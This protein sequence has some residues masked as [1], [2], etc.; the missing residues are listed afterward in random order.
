MKMI[1]VAYSSFPPAGNLIKWF[2]LVVGMALGHLCV[3]QGWELSIGGNSYDE[4]NAIEAAV[5]GG[6]IIVGFSESFGDDGDLDVLVTR[7]DIDGRVLWNRF[8]DEGFQE[9]GFDVLSE[10]DGTFLVVGDIKQ[11]PSTPFNVLLMKLTKEGKTLWSRQYDTPFREVGKTLTKSSDGGYLIA[12]STEDTDNGESDILLLKVDADGNFQWRKNLGTE[13]DDAAER[14]ITLEDGFLVAANSDNPDRIDSDIL[15]YKVDKTG[16]V[17]WTQRDS[18]STEEADEVYG[19]TLT[20]DKNIVIGGLVGFNSDAYI[21]KLDALTGKVIWESRIGG[22]MGDKIND[23]FEQPD[24]SLIGVG[25][26]EQSVSNLDALLV[27]LDAEGNEI[28]QSTLGEEE[29]IEYGVQV[30]PTLDGKFTFVGWKSEINRDVLSD[31]YLVKA[32]GQGNTITNLV[33]GRVYRD[34]DEGCNGYDLTRDVPLNDWLVQVSGKENGR[35]Y[36]GTTDEEG[37]YNILVDTGSYNV[38]VLPVNAYWSN[39]V[40]AGYEITLT[41]F[42]DTTTLNFPVTASIDCPYLEVDV[43][44]PF[45]TPCSDIVYTVDYCNIGTTGAQDAYVE[46]TLDES[47]EF[48]EADLPVAVQNNNLY[49]FNLGNIASAECGSFTISTRLP[50]SGIA[51]GQAALVSAHIFPDSLCTEPDPR[52]DGSSLIVT[53]NCDLDRANAPIE[54]RIRNVGKKDMIEPRPAIVTQDD[55]VWLRGGERPEIP[56][57]PAGGEWLVSIDDY[58]YGSTY[59]LILEQ[60]EFHPGRSFPTAYVEGCVEEGDDFNTGYATMFPENDLDPNISADVQ[61]VV[62]TDKAV[63]LRGYP[64]GYGDSLLVAETTDLTY[65]IFFRN[66]GNDT[67]NRVVIRDTLSNN[68]DITT[69]VPGASNYP[70]DFEIY[71]NGILKITF[72]GIELLPEGSVGDA[73]SYGFV[74]FSVSQKPDNPVGTLIENR[75]AVFFDYFAPVVTNVSRN[76]VGD[77]PSY[78]TTDIDRVFWAGVKINVYPNPFIESVV[79]DIEGYNFNDVI[80]SIFDTA[81]RLIHSSRHSGNEIMYYRNQLPSGLYFF[82]LETEG[83]LISSGKLSV[84]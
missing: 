72:S 26:S 16:E 68:L 57:L 49:T 44:T 10:E 62:G 77:F 67:I 82:K 12:G 64:K 51:E 32:D 21:A 73:E 5:D 38:S 37:R 22:P 42:Y 18:V 61:E 20:R 11:S 7:T 83:K 81:G 58:D 2:A 34:V 48:V 53:G 75:A 36:Y 40:E 60:S 84:R 78:I 65:T 15:L 46:V 55:I 9:H 35:V 79:F 19:L 30:V 17:I 33:T 69:V 24:G 59:R 52:W 28:W 41:E 63:E 80:L 50:C 54:F 25:Q 4:G 66:I 74:K 31:M 29:F 1:R 27:K 76:Y 43:S 13:E 3:A 14:V 6:F 47:L 39:C 23:I 56:A 45:L 70:Y 71:D 8:Y